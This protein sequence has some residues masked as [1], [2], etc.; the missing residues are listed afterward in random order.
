MT[1]GWTTQLT[2]WLRQAC[3]VD[4]L[5]RKPGNVTPEH[6]FTDARVSDFVT[7]AR[8]TAPILAQAGNLGIGRSIFEAVSATR[9]TVGHNTNL[10]MIL[11]LAPLA[12]VPS[13][14]P[15]SPGIR[16]VLHGLTVDDADWTY[17][18]VRMA[19]PGGLGASDVQDV[20]QPPTETLLKCMRHAAD[21]DLIALQYASGFSAVLGTGLCWLLESGETVDESDR[22][23]LVALQLLSEFGDSLIARKCGTAA[24]D[25][26][27]EQAGKVLAT[28]WP[29]SAAGQR[30]WDEFDVFLRSDGNRLNP[31]TTADM[32]AAIVFA[33]LRGGVYV[34]DADLM[35]CGEDEEAL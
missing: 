19:A 8:V 20:R 18:A 26:V 1:D 9:R 21:R 27:R 31:G 24:S 16:T 30:F 4:V 25:A 35:A 11:L 33:G 6:R 3:L 15:L 29:E 2:E 7:S 23:G 10:G 12:A 34:P 13:A 14:V 17:R 5:S 28:G 22:I 32:I